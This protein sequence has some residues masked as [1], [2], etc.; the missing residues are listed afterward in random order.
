EV[1][2]K[3]L[4]RRS[5]SNLSFRDTS[6]LFSTALLSITVF[7]FALWYVVYRV[8]KVDIGSTLAVLRVTQ[9]VLSTL[10]TIGLMNALEMLQWGLAGRNHGL[11]SSVFLGLSPTTHISGVFRIV[12]SRRSKWTARAGGLVRV[13]LVTAIWVA[14][15]VLFVKA[16]VITAYDPVFE[17]DVTAGVGQFDGSYIP[18]FMEKVKNISPEYPHQIVPFSVISTI[19][20][21]VGNSMYATNAP[22]LD[23]DGCDSYLLTGGVFLATPWIPIGYDSY[24]LVNIEKVQAS[25]IQFR[26]G[27]HETDA[28]RNEDCD[29]YGS[30]GFLIGIKMCVSKSKMFPGSITAGVYVCANG[31][32]SGECE[33]PLARPN[34]TTTMSVYKRTA[35]IVASRK[36]YS[37]S[38]VTNFGQAEQNSAIDIASF[39]N[40]LAWFL[41]FN[42]SST[43]PPSSVAEHFWNGQEQLGSP[44]WSSELTRLLQGMLAFP[45]WYFQPN[46]YGNPD[47]QMKD[48]ID[49]LPKEFYTKAQITRSYT[50][51]TIDR[52]MF[53]AF[54]ILE[55]LVLMSIWAILLWLWS[56]R[57]S[58]PKLSSYPL[59]DF[60]FKSK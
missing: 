7:A 48:M 46:N 54:I 4:P 47:L 55:S 34:I 33:R 58:L 28:F 50:R 23:C 19:Y 51:M 38:A 53:I 26:G 21:L 27:M 37:I 42:A 6:Y 13:I 8:L 44:Y 35:S 9:G 11:D 60:A 1:K 45:L 36:N 31:T 16:S 14:G 10:T 2:R 59:V 24:P 12:I 39:R 40:G 52:E 25:Q 5:Q 15:V 32:D 18:R 3:L 49:R 20:S 17:Y 43:P 41:D 57:P 29:V 56:T 30:E 22:P